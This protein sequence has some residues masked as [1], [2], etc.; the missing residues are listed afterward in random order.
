MTDRLRRWRLILGGDAADGTGVTLSGADQGMDLALAALYER[1]DGAEGKGDR[2]AGLG[3]SAPNVARW[4]GDI[5]TYFPT[6]VVRVMQQD[7]LE[8]LNLRRMLLEPEL[9]EAVEPDV[10]LVATLVSLRRVMPGR[11][12]E[13]ARRV[14]RRVVEELERR[15]ASPLRQAV[16]GSLNR[17]TRNRRPRHNEIDWHRTIRAN[18]RHYQPEYRTIIPESRIGHGRKRGSLR[19]VILCLDQSGSMA[20]SVVYAGVFAAVLASLPSVRTRVIAFDTAVADLTAD[21]HDPVEL[22]FGV[23]LGGGTDINRAVAYCQ[24][25]I[26]QPSE[27]ILILISDLYEGGVRDELVRRAAALVGS[28]VQMIALLALRDRGAPSFDHAVAAALSAVGVP[29]FACTPDLFPELMAAAIERRDI[30]QW[31][32]SH[33]VVVAR[34]EGT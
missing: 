15:L 17:S 18:L 16:V 7:A 22:L 19:E 14:V 31:A 21:L 20:S 26:R 5:R 10:D 3:S 24:S 9:L 29:A 6:S 23:Q 25:L 11:T 13:S 1:G 34:P 8:R 33:D 4:L 27:T 32:A 30:A 12:R 28:G 2:T